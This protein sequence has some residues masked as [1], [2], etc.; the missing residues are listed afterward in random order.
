MINHRHN[1]TRATCQPCSLQLIL[2]LPGDD[3]GTGKHGDDVVDDLRVLHRVGRLAD[4]RQQGERRVL[5][6]D[7]LRAETPVCDGAMEGMFSIQA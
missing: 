3:E 7:V 2:R 4:T 6:A 1:Q 5:R